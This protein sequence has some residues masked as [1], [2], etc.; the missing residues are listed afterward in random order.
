MCTFD[1][2]TFAMHPPP[3]EI[4][5]L[6]LYCIYT[7]SVQACCCCYRK[8]VLTPSSSIK[9]GFAEFMIF[10]LMASYS[11]CNLACDTI[12]LKLSCVVHPSLIYAPLLRTKSILSLKVTPGSSTCVIWTVFVFKVIL[13]MSSDEEIN[14]RA[15]KYNPSSET[16]PL[17]SKI[18]AFSAK[19]GEIYCGHIMAHVF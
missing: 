6:S 4:Y 17:M 11:K 14:S 13:K 3:R 2:C 16:D 5:S 9:Y 19:M 18:F 7:V 15:T 10:A 12:F 1:P 8:C